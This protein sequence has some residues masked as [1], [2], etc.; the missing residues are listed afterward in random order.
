MELSQCN[1]SAVPLANCYVLRSKRVIL[2]SILRAS[3]FSCAS[4]NKGAN[5]KKIKNELKNSKDRKRNYVIQFLQSHSRARA[6]LLKSVVKLG[7]MV[8]S[9]SC[10]S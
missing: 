8:C 4:K 9:G 3:F 10:C 2:F 6:R 1:F 5:E 7:S